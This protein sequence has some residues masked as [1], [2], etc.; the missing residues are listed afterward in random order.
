MS[1]KKNQFANPGKI[2]FMRLAPLMGG[3]SIVLVVL[4]IFLISTKGFV[5][6]ID[7]SGGTEI[8]VQFNE[9]P[10]VGEIR[11]AIEQAGLVG[12]SVQSFGTENEVLIRM[13]QPEGETPQETNKMNQ[14]MISLVTTTLKEKMNL[15]EE[16]LRRVDSVGPQVGSE[17]KRQAI[18]AIVYSLLVILIYVGLRFDFR[19]APGAVLCLFHDAIITL[20][21]YSLLGREV[22]IQ[23]MAAVL[24]IIGYSLNDTIVNYDRMRTNEP[25]YKDK[26]LSFVINRSV[27][28]M[29]SRTILTSTTTLISSLCL[30]GFGSGV[31]QDLA[32]T[33]TIGVVVGS[34]SSIY[35][36][37]PLVGV[38]DKVM[39]QFS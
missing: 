10:K 26:G 34:Y 32:F 15:P 11:A 23:V 33:F 39:K 29:L 12:A 9:A 25:L 28:D 30:Y 38:T 13:K 3:V 36:A 8:Q 1:S 22:N 16:G 5:F 37:C 21:I 19:Y 35:V 20:G 24:T 18:L 7:F 17:L 14:E 6:G 4:S 2:D 31:I 27:N